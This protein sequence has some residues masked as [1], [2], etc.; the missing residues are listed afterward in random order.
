MATLIFMRVLCALGWGFVCR[1]LVTRVRRTAVTSFSSCDKVLS[2]LCGWFLCTTI[3]NDSSASQSK[4]PVVVAGGPFVDGISDIFYVFVN[5]D[6]FGEATKSKNSK[7]DV[8]KNGIW[9]HFDF[10][11]EIRISQ[12]SRIWGQRVASA[13]PLWT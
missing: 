4:D 3:A 9:Q 5:L 12:G 1:L 13:S 6:S 8:K 11:G 2:Y 10:L 7:I